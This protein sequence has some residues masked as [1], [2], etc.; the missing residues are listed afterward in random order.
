MSVDKI[1]EALASRARREIL[2]YLSKTELTTSE[3]AT[4]FQMTAPS[5]SRHLTVLEPSYVVCAR[6]TLRIRRKIDA[7]ASI[8]KL[9]EDENGAEA[10]EQSILVRRAFSGPCG[11]RGPTLGDHGAL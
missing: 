2:A 1:F 8:D 9:L 6:R 3:L 5:M 10:A 11:D 7:I 4:R